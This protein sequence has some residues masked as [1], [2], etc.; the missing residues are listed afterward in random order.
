[1]TGAALLAF[2]SSPAGMSILGA[3]SAALA[4]YLGFKR[5]AKPQPQAEVKPFPKKPS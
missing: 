5:G 3:G 4:A 1:M 2:L